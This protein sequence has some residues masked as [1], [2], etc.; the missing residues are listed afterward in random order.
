MAMVQKPIN[1]LLSK[2]GIGKSKPTTR[3]LPESDH[4]YGKADI[5][6]QEGVAQGII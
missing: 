3:D 6:D 5:K 2:D 1:Y 4:F